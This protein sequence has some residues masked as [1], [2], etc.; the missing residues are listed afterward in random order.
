MSSPALTRSLNTGAAAR[1]VRVSTYR[2]LRTGAAPPY[3]A[4][5]TTPS[6]RPSA[7]NR[8][9]NGQPPRSETRR[10]HRTRPS[11]PNRVSA[12]PEVVPET[13]GVTTA[14]RPAVSPVGAGDAATSL[15]SAAALW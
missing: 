4:T 2:A 6:R 15:G 11:G 14:T 12:D 1:P 9:V 7:V 10:I 3:P 13:C 8:A 5:T